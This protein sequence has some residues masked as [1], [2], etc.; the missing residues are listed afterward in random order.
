L[1]LIE[2]QVKQRE[3]KKLALRTGAKVLQCIPFQGGF[4]DPIGRCVPLRII[5]I[6]IY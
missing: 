4:F 3:V 5:F 6:L 2:E 1:F